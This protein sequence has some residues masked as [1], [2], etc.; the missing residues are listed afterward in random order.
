MGVFFSPSI[1]HNAIKCLCNLPIMGRRKGGLTF[2][3]AGPVGQW[4]ESF[5]EVSVWCRGQAGLNRSWY[6][7]ISIP[8]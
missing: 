2:Q 1:W 6:I 7:C 4:K 5:L 3:K 8:C